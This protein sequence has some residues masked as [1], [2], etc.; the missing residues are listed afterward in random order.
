MTPKYALPALLLVLCPALARA[1]DAAPTLEAGDTA[2]VA[3]CA[4]IVMLMMLPGLGLFYAGMARS[5]NAL[6]VLT[7]IFA[8]IALICVLWLA[9]GYSLT[10]DAEGPWNAVIGGTGKLF[11]AGVTQDS[12]VG[13]IPEYTY[14]LFMMMF[15]AITPPII[16]GAFAERM[17][18]SAVLIFMAVWLSINYIPMA[19]MAWGGGWV[20]GVGVQ[21]FAGGNVVH[22][23]AGIAALVCALVVG[24]RKGYGSAMMAPHNMTMTYSGA[25]ML[26]VGWLAF[27]GGCALAANGFSA[28]VMLNTMLGGAGGALGWMA[29]EWVHRKRPS[30]FGLLSGC[31]GGLVAITPA[32]GFVGPAGAIAVGL[33]TAP[34][35]VYAVE[36]VKRRFGYD[37]AFDVFGVH[38]VGAMMGGVL[39]VIFA[40]PGLGGLG[41]PEGR[42]MI[43]QMVPQVLI[44]GFS[45]LVSLVTTWIALKVADALVGLRVGEGAEYDGLDLVEHGEVGFRLGDG[46]YAG[47]A[48]AAEGHGSAQPVAAATVERTA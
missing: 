48:V 37:D 9:Y 40:A 4:L 6:S 30:T 11:L 33:L 20:F 26:W 39:T 34:V 45:V 24:P 31:I 1:Q 17:K 2:F 12:L 7:Q 18:F 16:V 22:L 5:K 3:T 32:C 27:C 13:T 28:L 38:G 21:D 36:S 19:H 41:Y 10:F 43:S 46:V 25:A 15:A 42:G 14:M 44:M 35:C 47:A 29:T 8:S 23:N